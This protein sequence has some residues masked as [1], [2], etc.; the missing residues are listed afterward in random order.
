MYVIGGWLRDIDIYLNDVFTYDIT[1]NT[2][3]QISGLNHAKYGGACTVFEGKI[4]LT[5][6]RNYV[7]GNYH[8]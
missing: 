8:L 4:V 7:Q 6:G 1:S 5:D 3:H 2:W